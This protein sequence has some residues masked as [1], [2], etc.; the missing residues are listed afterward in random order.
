LAA[1][2]YATVPSPWPLLADVR[3]I[4]SFGDDAA[5]VQSREVDTVNVPAPPEADTVGDELLAV[6]EH[7]APLGPVIDVEDEPQPAANIAS[8]PAISLVPDQWIQVGCRDVRVPAN[9]G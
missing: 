8:T 6:T 4:H 3:A 1:T 9:T 7:F 5:H 2:R